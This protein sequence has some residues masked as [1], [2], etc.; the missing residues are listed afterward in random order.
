MK[1]VLKQ[2]LVIITICGVIFMLG[3]FWG[4]HTTY[5]V[6]QLIENDGTVT[7]EIGN[8]AS[9]EIE[10]TSSQLKGKVNINTADVGLLRQLP[11][12]GDVLAQRIVDYRSENGQFTSVEDL[13]NVEGF[14][15][16][17]LESLKE[18]ITI[19]YDFE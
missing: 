4:R 17:R 13:V 14:G 3:V 6:T 10:K 12:I 9:S 1:K 16:K 11:G 18:Y 15:E 2:P 7:K 5:S 8:S 19:G